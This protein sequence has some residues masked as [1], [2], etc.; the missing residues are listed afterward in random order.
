MEIN[1]AEIGIEKGRQYETI[2]ST[3]DENNVLNAAPIGVI[4]TGPDTILCRIFKGGK[5]LDNILTRKEFVVNI[6]HNPELFMMSTIG[7]LPEEYFNENT[8]IKNV[9]AYFKCKAMSF[10]EAVKQ[11]D[12]IKK[13]GEAIVIKSKAVEIHI[14]ND[15][16]AFNRAFGCVVESLSNFTRFDIVSDLEKEKYI[17]RFRENSRVVN[18][19]GYKQEKEAMLKIK[20]AL[21]KKGYE[22]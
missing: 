11:S 22:I 4:C 6:T 21:I 12:P 20:E 2:I 5:T 16:K 7:N 19:V 17:K 10:K 15:A 1:L 3:S 18:K 14:N 13:R 8:S 9:D